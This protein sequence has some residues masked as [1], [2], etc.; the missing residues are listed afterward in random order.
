MNQQPTKNFDNFFEIQRYRK[1]L[2]R[3]F[4]G[5]FLG[6]VML[7]ILALFVVFVLLVGA[8]TGEMNF[9]L[10]LTSTLVFLLIL[11]V[12]AWMRSHR[13]SNDGDKLAQKMGAVR[14]FVSQTDG[15]D[16]VQYFS[17]F[18]RAQSAKDLPKQLCSAL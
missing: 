17:T 14:L 6:V 1:R 7:H 3:V 11:V 15:V 9:S 8:V 5:L 16:K 4:F 2:R 13:L 18:I 10:W 12:G